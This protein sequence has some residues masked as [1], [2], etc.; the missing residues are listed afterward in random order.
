[1]AGPNVN[2]KRTLSALAIGTVA[3]ATA[4]QIA[5]PRASAPKVVPS[6]PSVS[7]PAIP[8]LW[9]V[10][11]FSFVS[12]K[13][14]RVTN[15]DLTGHV[16]IADFIFTQCTSVC[17]LITAKMVLLQRRLADPKLRF[18]SFSVDPAHDTPD[19]LAKYAD[20]WQSNE[21]RWLLLS[22]DP[23]GLE[24]ITR[25]LR[26]ALEKTGDPKNPIAHTSQFFLVDAEGSVRGYYS[27]DST[28]SFARLIDDATALANSAPPAPT[29]AQSSGARLYADL[30]C[31]ACH[32]RP[33]L[34]PSLVG[35]LG[36]T[37]LLDDGVRVT[38]NPE[39]IRDSIAHPNARLVAG[40]ARLMPEYENSLSAREISRLAEYVAS[41]RAGSVTTPRVVVFDSDSRAAV[42]LDPVCGMTVRVT[43]ATPRADYAGRQ[44]S[45][46]SDICRKRFEAAP[47]D[48]VPK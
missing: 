1:M 44:Y 7:A 23:S 30:G 37:V 10:P 20:T 16:W 8:V 40:Y 43:A 22:T 26:V 35:L 12:H 38:V 21:Q 48:Y 47:G 18:V 4:V 6:I 19:I 11:A 41:L 13:S 25:G 39:Y 24:T 46:C 28:E 32:A 5:R 42:E 29:A 15:R 27:S 45:F 2:P 9:N 17:P 3:I 14:Q 36:Q 31:D 34:A 33:D